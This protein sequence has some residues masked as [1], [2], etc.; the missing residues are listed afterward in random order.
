LIS[1]FFRLS[2]VEDNSVQCLDKPGDAKKLI[3]ASP[4]VVTF[5]MIKCS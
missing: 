2:I 5:L 4:R 1:I 3:M